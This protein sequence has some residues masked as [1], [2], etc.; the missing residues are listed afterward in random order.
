[1]NVIQADTS[2]LPVLAPL[3]DGYRQFYQQSSD[4]NLAEQFLGERLSQAV[5]LPPTKQCLFLL[6]QNLKQLFNLD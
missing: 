6:P 4:L 5:G 3:F 2:H 1:M